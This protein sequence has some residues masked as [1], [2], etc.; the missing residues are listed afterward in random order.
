MNDESTKKDQ[1]PDTGLPRTD[2]LLEKTAVREVASADVDSS[3]PKTADVVLPPNA[4]DEEHQTGDSRNDSEAE[5]V[6]PSDKDEALSKV[7]RK[8]FK[9]GDK[10]GELSEEIIQPGLGHG[11]RDSITT[12]EKEKGKEAREPITLATTETNNSSNLSSTTSSPTH[13]FRSS[14]RKDSDSIPSRSSPPDESNHGAEEVGSRKRKRKDLP[15]SRT[16]DKPRSA[17][18]QEMGLENANTHAQR[19]HRKSN[20]PDA[21]NERSGSPTSR[22]SHYRAQSTVSS[23]YQNQRKRRKPAPLNVATQRK[24]SEDA[25][26]ESDDS[27]SARIPANL[28][29]LASADITAQSPAKLPHKKLRDKN[30]RTL[31]ARACATEEVEQA[32]ARLKERPD[33]LDIA[34]NAGNTPLQIAALEG[35]AEIVKVLLDAGCDINCKN[36]DQDTPLIDAVENGHLDVVR[37]LLKAGLD[38]RQSNAKGEE[39]LDLLDP[40]DDNYEEIKAALIEYKEKDSRRRHSEDQYGQPSATKDS[41]SGHSPHGSPSLHSTRSPPIQLPTTRRRTARSE[42]TRNDLLWI[43]PTPENLR[44]KAGTGDVEIVDYI[45]N[46]RPIADIEAVLAAARGGH[47][48]VLELL[49]AIG[50]PNPDPEPLSTSNHKPGYNTPMLAAIGRG[51][52]EIVK[53]L[54]SE[55]GFDP[56]RRLYRNMTYYEIAKDR[57]GLHWQEEHDVL[58]QAYDRAMGHKSLNGGSDRT[59][60]G[61]VLSREGK[62]GK[63][64]TVPSTSKDS[65]KT[66]SPERTPKEIRRIKSQPVEGK[67]D[68]MSKEQRTESQ[69]DGIKH[70]RVP[71]EKSRDSSVALSE[72]GS[73]TR[74]SPTENRKTK[75][76]S[77]DAGLNAQEAREIIKPRRKL[78]S[79]KVYRSDLEKKR[80]ASSASEISSAS[81]QDH[82]KVKTEEPSQIPRKRREIS[83]ET[84]ADTV[85]VEQREHYKKRPHRSLSPSP[86]TDKLH[87]HKASD[88]PIKKKKRRRVDSEG[89]AIVQNE[90]PKPQHKPSTTQDKKSPPPTIDILVPGP[91]PAPIATMA[92]PVA[93]MGAAKLLLTPPIV[94]SKE[95]EPPSTDAHLK[96]LDDL[97]AQARSGRLQS[98]ERQEQEQARAREATEAEKAAELKVNEERKRE[99]LE[100]EAKEKAEREEAERLS[101]IE[102]EKEEAHLEAQRKAE[103]AERQA[104]AERDAEAARLEKKREEEELQKRRVEQE[105]LRR[106]EQERRRAEQEERERQSRIRKQEEEERRRREALPN[107]LRRAAE[108]GP[109][110]AKAPKEIL[111]WLPI[112]TVTGQQLGFSGEETKDERW[113]ANIQAAPILAITD[114]DLSQCKFYFP[115]CVIPPKA[116]Y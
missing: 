21:S 81:S 18:K 105:R 104:Q 93:N 71:K 112:Y 39:P 38:P 49:I 66:E 80:K 15:E 78:V 63:R 27:S 2:G 44:A 42:A 19:E 110:L 33:D 56:T 51:N 76:S 4:V 77:S 6:V 16:E 73:S 70:L 83:E 115:L 86:I 58:K 13:A 85:R 22:S 100:L 8:A 108:L 43:N 5:T 30:G 57:Q 41:V 74:D 1:S 53:L 50:K 48:V 45:L 52:P 109:E 89:N 47:K 34:D 111:K 91:G 60:N 20:R 64:N 69:R 75:R 65:V 90:E 99:Q 95:A 97:V 7:D 28:R 94:D 92:A 68:R 103:E 102:R 67:G 106:E 84:A 14:S 10:P 114:L 107:G 26:G 96:N 98:S 46:M 9:H 54:L 62:R 72:R 37:L 116:L 59:R 35:N 12:S 29:R 61:A 24:G 55:T 36:I 17:L 87:S 31:L 82:E 3:P 25:E 11:N 23:D 79:G 40:S 101:R 113:I 88:V 32:V